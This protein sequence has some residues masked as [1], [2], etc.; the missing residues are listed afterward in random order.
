MSHIL[1]N[2][3]ATKIEK[4]YEQLAKAINEAAHKKDL[5]TF[6]EYMGQKMCIDA[7]ITGKNTLAGFRSL[8]TFTGAL[9]SVMNNSETYLERRHQWPDVFENIEVF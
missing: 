4:I 3:M 9:M 5:A 8:F 2:M 1:I 6:E 7:H